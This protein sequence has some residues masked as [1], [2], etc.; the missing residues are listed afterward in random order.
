MRP[1]TTFYAHEGDYADLD[2]QGAAERL[3]RAVQC[4]TVNDGSSDGEFAALRALMRERYPAVMEAGTFEVV[5]RSVLIT[6]PGG[7][8]SLRPCLFMSHQDVVDVVEGTEDDWRYP[9]FSGTIA[10]GYVWGRGTLDVKNQVFGLL[11]AA[12]YLLG[13]GRTFTRTVYLAFGED[14][15]TFN[16]GALAISELLQSRGVTLEFVLDEGD[17]EIAPGDAFGAPE[18]FVFQIALAEKGYADLELSV[19]SKGGHSSRPFGGTSLGRLSQAIARIAEHPF[20]AACSPVL[21]NAFRAAAPYVTQEPLRTLVQDVDANAQSI[22]DYCNQTPALFPLTTTTIAPTMISGGSSACNVMPQDMRAVINF[23]IAP[24]ETAAGVMAR[25]AAAVDD[26]AVRLRFL[27]ANDPSEIARCDGYG[28]ARVKAAMERYY[29]DV[30]FLPSM[31]VGATDARRYEP[32]C[33]T[34]IRC[35]PFVSEGEDVHTGV[36]GTNE[37]ISLRALAQ[38]IRVLIHLM[39]DPCM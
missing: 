37:R 11:E 14:E 8:A 2:I 24:G 12:E 17:G 3:S 20:P 32:I 6:L 19:Q 13:H 7:D 1:V 34:C 33:D 31:S 25:C 39:E 23:R 29:Q 5:G 21:Q 4:R 18:Q 10:E 38:G 30:V 16:T 26:P 9:P 28:Y 15:E 36:H 22:A 35:A 27:Q